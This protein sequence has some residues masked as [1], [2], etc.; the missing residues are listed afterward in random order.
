MRTAGMLTQFG[1]KSY[2]VCPNCQ[3][4]YTTDKSTRRRAVWIV[5]FALITVGLSAGAMVMGFPWGLASVVSG[6][7][8]LVYVGYT[9]SKMSY[10]EYRGKR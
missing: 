9:L 8:L 1:L 3:S 10:V 2:R 7:A 4:K 5:I 6:T